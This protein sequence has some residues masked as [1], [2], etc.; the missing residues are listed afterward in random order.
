MEYQSMDLS[1]QRDAISYGVSWWF[2]LIGL[3]FLFIR[4]LYI[5]LRDRISIP[6]SGNKYVLPALTQWQK[7]SKIIYAELWENM[8]ESY[9][10]SGVK[11]II[12]E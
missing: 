9:L 7:K 12:G 3:V 11:D 5:C 4:P 2:A 10:C 8:V 1:F 6:D